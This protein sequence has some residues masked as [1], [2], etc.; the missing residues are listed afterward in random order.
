MLLG[1]IIVI[2]FI[3]Q[4]SVYALK[5]IML[6]FR[7]GIKRGQLFF[8]AKFNQILLT[9]N[10]RPEEKSHFSLHI[11]SMGGEE[12]KEEGKKGITMVCPAKR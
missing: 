2:N 5:V 1:E 3:S 11:A 4:R 9:F 8:T 6:S 7:K 10:K 12:F